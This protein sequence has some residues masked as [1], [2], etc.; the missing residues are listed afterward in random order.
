MTTLP[1][2]FTIKQKL[3]PQ[4][5]RVLIS[6]PLMNDGIFGRSVIL[7]TEHNKH[8]SIGYILNKH[9]GFT[10]QQLLPLFKGFTLPVFIGG[11]VATNTVHFIYQS[12][13][14]LTN[15]IQIGE[16]L[17]WGGN[18]NELLEL[19]KSNKLNEKNV[20]FFA[21]YSGWER[22]QLNKELD[23]GYWVVNHFDKE[24]YFDEKDASTLWKRNVILMDSKFHFWLN[25]PTNPTLN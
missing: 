18:M 23:K 2:I 1:N 13:E 11:P 14:K 25:I 15:T 22:N 10:I 12:N 16:N 8:G 17:Y 9:S 4:A 19:M 20:R 6:S 24:L 7:L 21:G 5:G 3:A